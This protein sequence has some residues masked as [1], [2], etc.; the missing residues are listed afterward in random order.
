SLTKA[1]LR[2]LAIEKKKSRMPAYGEVF[3]SS[4]LDD[5]VAY[6]YSLQK[7]ARGQ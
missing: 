1:D 4:E 7:N 5:L 2:S 3:T 6:L